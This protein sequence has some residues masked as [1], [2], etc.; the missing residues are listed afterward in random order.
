MHHNKHQHK[1]K[2]VVPFLL[3]LLILFLCSLEIY[4]LFFQSGG[5]INSATTETTQTEEPLTFDASKQKNF[6]QEVPP[7]SPLAVNL[8]KQLVSA[9]FIGTALVVHE[10]QIILQQGYGYGNFETKQKNNSQSLFQIGSMQKAYTAVLILKQI[11]AKKLSLETTVDTYYPNIPNSSQITIRH[12]LMM[13]SGLYQEEHPKAMMTDDEFIRYNIAH[14]KMGTFNTFRYDGINYNLL[15][16]I[17]E[18]VTD[19]PYKSLFNQEYIT[20]LH[21]SN[22]IFYDTFIQ[23]PNRT[24]SYEKDK[25]KDYTKKNKDN[26]VLFDQEVGTGNVAA[27]TGDV[28]T[29]FADLFSNQLLTS[30]TM[31]TIWTSTGSGNYIAGT[32]DFGNYIFSHGIEGGFEAAS[33]VSKNQKDAV[34]LLTNQHLPDGSYVHLDKNL[35]SQL[36]PYKIK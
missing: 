1:K 31:N 6:A 21:L 28:Y 25:N 30:T 19:T 12:L 11:Q 22:T 36:G 33:C 18:K 24:Y 27:T 5:K 34:I 35:F 14:A 29:F 32:Y 4:F 23:S 8:D 13:T 2:A 17:L 3:L 7:T 15:V 9:D 26:A 20:D 10:G 16:G